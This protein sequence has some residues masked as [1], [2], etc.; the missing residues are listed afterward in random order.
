MPAGTPA[1]SRLLVCAASALNMPAGA[2]PVLCHRLVERG[3]EPRGPGAVHGRMPAAQGGNERHAG[4]GG[5]GG[6]RVSACAHVHVPA[7]AYVHD[8]S[9]EAMVRFRT[10]VWRILQTQVGGLVLR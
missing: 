8:L 3:G 6:V 4:A 7:Y 2:A 10:D 5:S 9:V 1:A